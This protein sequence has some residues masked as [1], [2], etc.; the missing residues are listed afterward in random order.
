MHSKLPTDVADKLWVPTLASSCWLRVPGQESVGGRDE[1]ACAR[2]RH[3]ER[4][5]DVDAVAAS[6]RLRSLAVLAS[7]GGRARFI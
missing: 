4:T 3:V 5:A 6:L 1:C 2:H 7:E